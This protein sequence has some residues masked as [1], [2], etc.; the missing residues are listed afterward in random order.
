MKIGI[1][2]HH[3]GRNNYGQYL[4][5][6][7]MQT[8]LRA[9]GHTPFLIDYVPQLQ[10]TGSRR[11]ISKIFHLLKVISFCY[12][13]SLQWYCRK[14]ESERY[15]NFLQFRKKYFAISP[16]HYSNLWELQKNPPEADIYL[17]G[18]DQ[19]WNPFGNSSVLHPFFLDFGNED[20]KRIAYAASW[21]R[22]SITDE[23]KKAVIPLIRRFQAVSVREN[24]GIAL[25]RQCGYPEAVTVPDPTFLLT[26]EQ[27]R[28]ISEPPIRQKRKYVLCY[29]LTNSDAFAYRHLHKWAKRRNMEIK[30]V[31]G[32]NFHDIHKAIYPTIPEWLGLID[33]AEYVITNSFHGVVFA[34]LFGKKFGVLPLTGAD[35]PMNTRL[36]SLFEMIGIDSPYLSG[37]DFS[38]LERSYSIDLAEIRAKAEEFLLKTIKK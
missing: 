17:T 27:Y 26:V 25:C 19:V 4:Q 36:E 35:S 28:K 38:V 9:Q 20:I 32:N 8:W 24:S 3:W 14:G 5:H 15:S 16:V 21:G 34:I 37:N 7:A 33:K 13:T 12:H 10:Q 29:R 6:Y 11:R 22:T 18:S 31:T 30:Y 23:E 1:M 2:T